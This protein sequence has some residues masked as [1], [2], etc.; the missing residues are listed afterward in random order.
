MGCG[1]SSA[2]SSTAIAPA[3]GASSSHGT[4]SAAR[5]AAAVSP[6]AIPVERGHTAAQCALHVLFSR[7]DK[8][9]ANMLVATDLA[10]MQLEVA[11]AAKPNKTI[12]KV[13]PALEPAAAEPR[14]SGRLRGETVAEPP[15]IGLRGAAARAV[16]P[17]WLDL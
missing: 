8:K 12:T 3:G 1:S 9:N 11:S 7:H 15:W 10:S 2:G 4:S 5:A 17:A 6:S 13:K 14:R 16:E